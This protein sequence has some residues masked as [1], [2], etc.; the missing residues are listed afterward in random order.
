MSE[1]ETVQD[2]NNLR[3]ML[4]AT[5]RYKPTQWG[6]RN[7]FITSEGH[8]DLPSMERLHK[9]GLV[10]K[11]GNHY[12]FATEAGMRAIGFTDRQ[13]KRAMES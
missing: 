11:G 5:E 10:A 2:M 6:F 13:V 4:G 1:N 12:W 3:H 8:D 7:R 9:Q